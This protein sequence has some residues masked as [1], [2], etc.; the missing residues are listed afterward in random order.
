MTDGAVPPTRW[1]GVPSADAPPACK[2]KL[3]R[4]WPLKKQEEDYEGTP[5]T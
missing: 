5:S 4:A 3:Q 2:G 1:W